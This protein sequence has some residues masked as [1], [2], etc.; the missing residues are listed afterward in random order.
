[1]KRLTLLEEW[2][3]KLGSEY[4]GHHGH[5]G[6]PGQRGGSAPRSSGSL[7]VYSELKTFIG[8]LTRTGGDIGEITLSDE[9]REL[10]QETVTEESLHLYRGFGLV[11]GRI[12]EDKMWEIKRMRPGDPIPEGLLTKQGNV[13]ASYTHKKGYCQTIF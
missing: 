1:M 2:Y 7:D 4:S 6:V 12:A 13:F 3:K 10:L 11:K 9:A 5:K 8:R